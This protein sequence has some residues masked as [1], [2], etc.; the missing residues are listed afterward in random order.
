MMHEFMKFKVW[1]TYFS[2]LVALKKVL[3]YNLRA[4][5][6]FESF[7]QP[8]WDLLVAFD[9]RFAALS[10]VRKRERESLQGE[11]GRRKPANEPARGSLR[12]R[13]SWLR[14]GRRWRISAKK[15]KKERNCE[16]EYVYSYSDSGEL[17]DKERIFPTTPKS[18]FLRISYSKRF[19]VFRVMKKLF[20]SR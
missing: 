6:S 16:I 14:D 2:H 7:T 11:A 8:F 18:I 12:S 19:F 3:L 1:R 13:F 15:S 17:F 9:R 10:P 20:V 4:K 5:M